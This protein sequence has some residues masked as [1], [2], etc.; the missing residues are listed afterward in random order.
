MVRDNGRGIPE[1]DLASV[2]D[3]FHRADDAR[4]GGHAGLGLAI[5]KGIVELHGGRAVIQSELGAGAAASLW[6]PDRI[7]A[8]P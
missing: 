2:F 8:G 3:R 4:V 6:W 5:V 1:K 7:A